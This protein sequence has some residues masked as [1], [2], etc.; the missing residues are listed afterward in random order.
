MR[1]AFCLIVAFG[2]CLSPAAALAVDVSYDFSNNP[3]AG[4]APVVRHRQQ[5]HLR[6]RLRQPIRVECPGVSRGS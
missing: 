4:A 1:N 2:A 6:P 5:Q 3:L